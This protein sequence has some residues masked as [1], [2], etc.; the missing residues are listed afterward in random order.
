MVAMGYHR[1]AAAET[2]RFLL[3]AL[4]RNTAGNMSGVLQLMAAMAM[5]WCPFPSNH[6]LQ[7]VQY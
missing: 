5:M 1:N 3:V 4:I 2:S 6:F 7:H